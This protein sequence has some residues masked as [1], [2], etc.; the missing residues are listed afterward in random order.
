MH[1]I[2]L[3]RSDRLVWG[4]CPCSGRAPGAELPL[5]EL[6]FWPSIYRRPFLYWSSDRVI[7]F[8]ESYVDALKFEPLLATQSLMQLIRWSYVFTG[9]TKFLGSTELALST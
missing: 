4:Q 6:N 1:V 5:V 7:T 8:D 3:M 2:L 9:I